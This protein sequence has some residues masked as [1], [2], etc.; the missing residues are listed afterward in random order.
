MVERRPKRKR[1]SDCALEDVESHQPV[2][3]GNCAPPGATAIVEYTSVPPPRKRRKVRHAATTNG[4]IGGHLRRHRAVACAVA[5]V[6][7]KGGNVVWWSQDPMSSRVH[8]PSP[9]FHRGSNDGLG[10]LSSFYRSVHEQER[11]PFESVE[12]HKSVFASGDVLTHDSE[13]TNVPRPMFHPSLHRNPRNFASS[14]AQATAD[15]DT[16][17]VSDRCTVLPSTGQWS[18]ASTPRPVL[19][20]AVDLGFGIHDNSSHQDC[21]RDLPPQNVTKNAKQDRRFSMVGGFVSPSYGVLDSALSCWTIRSS[22]V[23]A[24]NEVATWTGQDAMFRFVAVDRGIPFVAPSF[25]GYQ[26]QTVVSNDT[27]TPLSGSSEFLERPRHPT[28]TSVSDSD[29]GLSRTSWT[30][31]SWPIDRSEIKKK[32]RTCPVDASDPLRDVT[33]APRDR[34]KFR[35]DAGWIVDPNISPF[36]QKFDPAT[37][38]ALVGPPS[39]PFPRNDTISAQL[40]R[41]SSLKRKIEMAASNATSDDVDSKRMLVKYRSHRPAFLIVRQQKRIPLAAHVELDSRPASSHI[42]SMQVQTHTTTVQGPETR[43]VAAASTNSRD[44]AYDST[45]ATPFRSMIASSKLVLV[46]TARLALDHVTTVSRLLVALKHG[47]ASTILVP[48]TLTNWIRHARGPGGHAKPPVHHPNH[49]REQRAIAK[50]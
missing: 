46:F 43:E 2:E 8:V 6:A 49:S 15:G 10:D 47:A 42:G 50:R 32:C 28:S 22:F 30:N 31:G 44:A 9:R 13:E 37:N 3:D 21:T 48:R 41:T 39:F 12:A 4:R 26:Q 14:D 17:L 25:Q 16:W 27:R 45:H 18:E 24:G 33:C 34:I 38:F 19:L 23:P 7:R 1:D 36:M 40:D 5:T 11:D 20:D 35:H 29:G